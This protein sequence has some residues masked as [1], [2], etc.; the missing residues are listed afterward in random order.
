MAAS[1]RF[2]PAPC[3][4]DNPLHDLKC[5]EF[6]LLVG[7]VFFES[8]D[9]TELPL[10]QQ[11][12]KAMDMRVATADINSAVYNAVFSSL[13]TDEL[14]MHDHSTTT[15]Q[16]RIDLAEISSTEYRADAYSFCS[17]SCVVVTIR[18][19][20][21]NFKYVNPK[22]LEIAH[23]SCADSFSISNSS[24]ERFLNVDNFPERVVENYYECVQTTS[25]AFV[26]SVGIAFGTVRQI[27]SFIHSFIHSSIY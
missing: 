7:L 23:G 27:H 25:E 26:S 4:C 5:D 14:K 18:M 15:V 20:D 6:D 12:E 10:A 3:N 17:G 1:S 22:Y 19:H 21:V 2:R 8:E 24:W 9:G 11:F 13:V 16:E